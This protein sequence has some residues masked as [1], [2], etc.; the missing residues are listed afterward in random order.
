MSQT[1][2]LSSSNIYSVY[3][4][5]VWFLSSTGRLAKDNR[6]PMNRPVKKETPFR[7]PHI[8]YEILLAG[9]SLETALCHHAFLRNLLIKE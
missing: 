9:G 8:Y 3:L 6:K 5:A 7:D 1:A 4:G 2:P